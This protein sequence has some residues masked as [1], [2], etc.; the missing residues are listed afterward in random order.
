MDGRGSWMKPNGM[1]RK[2][3]TTNPFENFISRSHSTVNL[4]TRRTHA[5][6]LWA[7]T[8]RSHSPLLVHRLPDVET[9]SHFVLPRHELGF[10]FCCHFSIDGTE[11]FSEMKSFNMCH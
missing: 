1:G 2:R 8:R 6:V 4:A 10:L 7:F 5:M 9:Y 11:S 3:W